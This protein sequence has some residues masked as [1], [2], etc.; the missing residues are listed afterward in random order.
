M[1]R[2]RKDLTEVVGPMVGEERAQRRNRRNEALAERDAFIATHRVSV[3][4]VVG[5]LT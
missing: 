5:S 3:R 4:D 2:M 1:I